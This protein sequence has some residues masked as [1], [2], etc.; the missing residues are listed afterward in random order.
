MLES[1]QVQYRG[2]HVVDMGLV[3]HDIETE[4]IGCPNRPAAI[5]P[6]SRHPNAVSERVV[7]AAFTAF[8]KAVELYQWGAAELTRP[9]DERGVQQASFL[10][11]DYS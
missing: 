8:L 9:N 1:E 6:C 10:N 3:L 7:V 5:D 11:P 4:L 2:L